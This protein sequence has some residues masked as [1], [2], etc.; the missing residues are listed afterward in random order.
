MRAIYAYGVYMP[1]IGLLTKTIA[2]HENE[3]I[4]RFKEFEPRLSWTEA[5]DSGYKMKKLVI[6]ELR[7]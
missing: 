5:V 1:T 4:K 2:E 7:E 6:V 3:A